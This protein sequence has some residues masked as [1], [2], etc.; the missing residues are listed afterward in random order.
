MPYIKLPVLPAIIPFI[1]S[2]FCCYYLI[3]Y[4]LSEYTYILG[5]ETLKIEKGK[6]Y[7][8]T[9]LLNIYLK[10][11]ISLK[12]ENVKV[13]SLTVSPFSKDYLILSYKDKGNIVK[14][15]IH[16]HPQLYKNLGDRLYE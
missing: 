3:K 16:N 8:K 12:Q 14:V 9:E 6:D 7:K 15:K 2:V 13:K 4:T 1:Y 10:D 5:E 11:I